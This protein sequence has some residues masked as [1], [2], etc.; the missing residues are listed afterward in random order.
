M[1]TVKVLVRVRPIISLEKNTIKA[2]H[3]ETNVRVSAT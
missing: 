3:V 2:V 1:S